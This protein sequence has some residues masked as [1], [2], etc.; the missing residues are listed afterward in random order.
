MAQAPDLIVRA[1]RDLVS[2]FFQKKAAN[3]WP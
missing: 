2:G 3:G 1:P